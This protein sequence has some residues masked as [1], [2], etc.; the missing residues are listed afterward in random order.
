[1]AAQKTGNPSLY[2]GL[3]RPCWYA[4]SRFLDGLWT[5]KLGQLTFPILA[6]GLKMTH[7]D[8]AETPNLLRDTGYFQRHLVTRLLKRLGLPQMLGADQHA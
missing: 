7:L 3:A 1:M 4:S 6:C 8:V 2:A 5:A